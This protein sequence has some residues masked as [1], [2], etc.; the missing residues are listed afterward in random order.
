MTFD[1]SSVRTNGSKTRAN[2]NRPAAPVA[3]R[4]VGHGRVEPIA[5]SA[6]AMINTNSITR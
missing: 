3:T 5:P 6:T 2:T 1:G 4:R